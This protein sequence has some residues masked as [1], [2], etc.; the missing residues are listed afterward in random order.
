MIGNF[1]NETKQKDSLPEIDLEEHIQVYKNLFQN[2]WV[3]R[4]HWRQ[5]QQF[6][7]PYTGRNLWGLRDPYE[8][9]G[10]RKDQFRINAGPWLAK[11]EL[12]A[13]F[14]EGMTPKDRPFFGFTLPDDNLMEDQ[15]VQEYLFACR[16]IC[17]GLME[18]SGFYDEMKSLYGELAVY[19]SGNLVIYE[20]PIQG[21]ICQADTIGEFVYGTGAHGKVD[22]TYRRKLKRVGSMVKEWG[23]DNCPCEIQQ[24]FESGQVDKEWMVV[25]AIVP[26]DY[27]DSSKGGT[28]AMQYESFYFLE[29]AIGSKTEPS[30]ADQWAIDRRRF[31]SKPNLTPRWG[32]VGGSIY[33]ISP[34]MQV[35]GDI[36]QIQKLE[37]KKLL[38]I[39]K[40]I[41]PPMLA[42]DSLRAVGIR[43]GPGQTNYYSAPMAPEQVAPVYNL[44]FNIKDTAEEINNV[45]Q[46]IDRAMF[47]DV[48]MAMT[49]M[50]EQNRGQSTAY[51][52]SRVWEEKMAR[53]GPVVDS[54]ENE[55]LRPAINR[56]FEIALSLGLLPPPPPNLPPGMEMKI[57]YTSFLSQSK[58]QIGLSSIQQALG[59]AGQQAQINPKSALLW[60]YEEAQR[61]VNGSL[62][63]NPKLLLSKEEYQK[64]LQQMQQEQQQQQ[65]MQQA[66]PLANAAQKL[67][68]TQVNGKSVLDHMTGGKGRAA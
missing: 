27:F 45:M 57:E 46:R 61:E 3:F 54:I 58:K 67:S 50:S 11:N 63:I 47:R 33:G 39:D 1:L 10:M 48:F 49:Q 19:G 14:A 9:L 21:A 25:H 31:R 38:G 59:F 2:M 42:P 40:T 23:F 29:G 20:D 30:S 32:V 55:V 68:Q 52:A 5:V 18:R 65:A 53:I 62:G 24:N 12:V 66:Q 28:S 4:D 7:D 60:N 43:V 26:A 64:A 17:L 41:D 16:D 37:S 35:L 13:G 56:F 22:R 36:K 15:L 44:Q 6:T 8:D 51:E 34:I